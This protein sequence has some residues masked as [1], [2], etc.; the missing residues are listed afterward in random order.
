MTYGV[1]V[2]GFFFS[3]LCDTLKTYRG[4]PSQQR[5]GSAVKKRIDIG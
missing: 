2:L 4:P 3:L 1:I 5:K